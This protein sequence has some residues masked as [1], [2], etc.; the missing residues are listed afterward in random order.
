[1]DWRGHRY[2]EVLWIGKIV[3]IGGVAVHRKQCCVWSQTIV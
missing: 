2:M 3:L 1:M